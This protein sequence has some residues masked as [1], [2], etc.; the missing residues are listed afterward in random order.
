MK[1][2]LIFL[3]L[4]SGAVHANETRTMSVEHL[5]T[6]ESFFKVTVK[7]DGLLNG[8]YPGWCA[9]WNTRIED[10]TV[11]NSKF[12]SSLSSNI[13]GDVV[14]HPEHLDEVNWIINQ[15]Y[16]GKTAPNGLGIY[17]IGDVQLA[18]WSLIDDEFDPASAGEHSMARVNVL[19][20]LAEV[21]GSNYEPGCRQLVG[22]ILIPS[23]PTNGSNSQ[24]TI[25][26]VP[27][28][29]FPKCIVPESDED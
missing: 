7:D 29:H 12:Y 4:I 22:I 26:L 23:N 16:V 8:V 18:I 27:R 21:E 3:F 25:I 10:H 5:L 15:N 6:G 2:L 28:Y 17:T 9:D 14:D 1:A 19:I 24:N 11:Y 20:A 13:P